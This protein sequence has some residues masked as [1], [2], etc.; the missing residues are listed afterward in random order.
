MGY[1]VI[2]LVV[3]AAIGVG[4]TPPPPITDVRPVTLHP[5]INVVPGF[6]PGGGTATII[7][8]WRGNGNAHGHHTW[9]VLGGATEGNP[10][11]V[12][13]IEGGERL[14]DA[15]TDDLFDGERV[16]GAVRF[17]RARVAG[18]PPA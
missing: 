13:G 9:M 10:V 2:G 17:A 12:V 15:V 1:G 7:E 11:G 4:M 3:A 5:G 16:L 18:R 8:A 6:L 14:V